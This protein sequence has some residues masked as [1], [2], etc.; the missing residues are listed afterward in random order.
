VIDIID[1]DLSY[2]TK[3]AASRTIRM[4]IDGRVQFGGELVEAAA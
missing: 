2:L 4:G 1:L 3:C